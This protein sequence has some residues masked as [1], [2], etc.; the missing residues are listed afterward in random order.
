MLAED[1]HQLRAP[2]DVHGRPVQE[3]LRILLGEFE[4][5][6]PVLL[7][8]AVF[9]E[10]GLEGLLLHERVAEGARRDV[11][12]AQGPVGALGDQGLELGAEL[13]R[14]G[15]LHLQLGLRLVGV[16]E[17]VL[18][19]FLRDRPA[20]VAGRLVADGGRHL[21]QL[22]V[23]LGGAVG[24]L[25]H[26]EV[27]LRG[28]DAAGLER[29]DLLVEVLGLAPEHHDGDGHL[30]AAGD[31]A[32]DHAG[33]GGGPLLV[34][35]V[36]D[37]L[38]DQLALGAPDLAGGV[39][40]LLA[41]LD[42]EGHQLVEV[43]HDVLGARDDA[44][45]GGGERVGERLVDG[46]DVRFGEAE[47]GVAGELGAERIDGGLV[48]R[49]REVEVVRDRE[50]DRMLDAVDGRG[51][52]DVLPGGHAG[53]SL[54]ACGLGGGVELAEERGPVEAGVVGGGLDAHGGC[55]VGVRW[56]NR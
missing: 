34:G 21:L 53:C 18:A 16:P 43:E 17:A 6:V 39:A 55:L 31:R 46:L 52:G 50:R 3:A 38:L 26:G 11:G 33:E 45:G 9:G 27:V 30:D 4:V 54:R 51:D 15:V 47:G 1:A 23:R 7:G 13:V 24:R 28:G 12:R 49:G 36:L 35:L 20:H 29:V 22:G 42:E 2:L 8:Y 48:D 44:R 10:L 40:L 41:D 19:D 5:G 37:A 25:E 56:L 32:E 14:L